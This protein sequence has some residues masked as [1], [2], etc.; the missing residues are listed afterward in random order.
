[1][2]HFDRQPVDQIITENTTIFWLR[3]DLRLADNAGFFHALKE[4]TE[5]LP[6]FIFDSEILNNL[7]DPRDLR[8]KFIH[9]SLTLLKQQ[10][11]Q[12]SSSLLVFHGNPTEVFQFIHAKNVYTNHDYEPYARTRDEAVEKILKAK[13]I[14][15]KTYKDQVIFEKSEVVKDDG[16]PYTVFTPY[17]KKWKA[18]LKSSDTKSFA[19]QDYLSHFKKTQVLRMPTLNEI[20]FQESDFIFPDREV[21]QSIVEKYDEQRNFPGIDGT[22]KLSVHLRFGTVSIRQLAQIGVKKTKGG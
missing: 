8:V 20:G 12:L 5:V 16:S 22:T 21:R 15:F 3:R 7:D 9:E 14:E 6:V 1:L 4:N 2:K 18:K 10:L 13:S 17:S 11:E 19:M